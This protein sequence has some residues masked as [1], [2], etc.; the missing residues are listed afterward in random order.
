[1]GMIRH[2]GLD[3]LQVKARKSSS[4]N[5]KNVPAMKA[6]EVLPNSSPAGGTKVE[7][8]IPVKK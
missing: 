6:I 3:L 1:M 5:V 2:Q 4:Q 8:S 7:K